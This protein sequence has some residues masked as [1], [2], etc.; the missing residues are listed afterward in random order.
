MAS[1]DAPEEAKARYPGTE[2]IGNRFVLAAEADMELGRGFDLDGD[3]RL[4][5]VN[6]RWE[7]V[8]DHLYQPSQTVG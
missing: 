2:L 6:P 4:V 5:A 8:G 1:E 3:W 7:P